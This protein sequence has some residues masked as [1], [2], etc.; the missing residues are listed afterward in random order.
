MLAAVH[1]KRR[2]QKKT[3]K[4]LTQQV[5]GGLESISKKIFVNILKYGNIKLNNK[6]KI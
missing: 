1:R 2:R 3:V 5:T 4:N 6:M